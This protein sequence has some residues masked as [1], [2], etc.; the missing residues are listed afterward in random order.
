MRDLGRLPRRERRLEFLSLLV[1]LFLDLVEPTLG[2]LYALTIERL[3][4]LDPLLLCV[5]CR[6]ERVLIP[7]LRLDDVKH[8]LA[9]PE[10]KI[11]KFVL[12]GRVSLPGERLRLLDLVLECGEV[13]LGP[14]LADI[15]PL[16]VAVG[17]LDFILNPKR[18][19]DRL[20]ELVVLLL[21]VCDLLL[22]PGDG[23]ARLLVGGFCPVRET[24]IGGLGL[25]H[26][27]GCPILGELQVLRGERGVLLRLRQ[28]AEGKC[29][30]IHRVG[31]I[32]K[33]PCQVAGREFV[34][35]GCLG[36]LPGLERSAF[37]DDGLGLERFD[38]GEDLLLPLL[39]YL[40]L[41][42][43]LLGR[44]AGKIHRL[45]KHGVILLLS[46]GGVPRGR[47]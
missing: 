17:V 7:I 24:T 2:A 4:G 41:I 22:M 25:P 44:L 13:A 42:L 8:G 1:D 14:D 6:F 11:Y 21:Q 28:V 9:F 46:F 45:P 18:L 33:L 23:L 5:A 20:L 29:A 37:G 19:V 43:D 38:V 10:V 36:R 15:R 35:A 3:L 27:L 47:D 39:E 16:D 32:P 40:D 26:R 34:P 30:I 12:R 31:C